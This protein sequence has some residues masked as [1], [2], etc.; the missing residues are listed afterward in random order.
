[1]GE[2]KMNPQ[3]I[4]T[5]IYRNF[6]DP[7]F[8]VQTLARDLNIS[9]S[10]LFETVNLNYNCTPHYLIESTRLGQAIKLLARDDLKI[11]SICNRSWYANLETF[12]NAVKKRTG[13]TP[14][15]LRDIVR[16]STDSQLE[17]TQVELC[18]KIRLFSYHPKMRK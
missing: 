1:M 16:N 5:L 13:Y 12:R 14:S 10:Y 6:N 11:Y 2:N 4:R 8:N 9:E 3:I 17:I 7:S 15:D 18:F